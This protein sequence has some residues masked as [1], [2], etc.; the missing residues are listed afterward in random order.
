M[1]TRRRKAM[2]DDERTRCWD[3]RNA[4]GQARAHELGLTEADVE[5]AVRA[6][7]EKRCRHQTAAAKEDGNGKP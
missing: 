6:V 3:D 1:S 4:Y 5:S 2:H 7:R